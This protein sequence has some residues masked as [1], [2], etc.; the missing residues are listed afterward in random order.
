MT[1][2][3]LREPECVSI[4][5]ILAYFVLFFGS[6]AVCPVR[7]KHRLDCKEVDRLFAFTFF[8]ILFAFVYSLY[9]YFAA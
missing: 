1:H 6:L 2:P 4:V 8:Y 7:N 3:S 5:W 9:A